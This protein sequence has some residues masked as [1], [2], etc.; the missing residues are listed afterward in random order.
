MKTRLFILFTIAIVFI[1]NIGANEQ[2]ENNINF[3]TNTSDSIKNKQ[4][5]QKRLLE[6]GEDVAIQIAKEELKNLNGVQ[7]KTLTYTRDLVKLNNNEFPLPLEVNALLEDSTTNEQY[8]ATAILEKAFF[9][10]VEGFNSCLV[11]PLTVKTPK[12]LIKSQLNI[13]SNRN[14]H[15]FRIIETNLTIPIDSTKNNL[16]VYITSNLKGIMLQTT[17]YQNNKIVEQLDG[18]ASTIGILDN[19]QGRISR[20]HNKK[21][22]KERFTNINVLKERSNRSILYGNIES[23]I[24]RNNMLAKPVTI[25]PG[26]L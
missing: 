22:I 24:I 9:R 4:E 14:S 11:L 6:F 1:G 26:S 16:D 12:G 20:H 2:N 5:L 7:K 25:V 10:D 21:I 8:I 3:S 23:Y 13:Y 19:Y 17:F 18:I 15:F